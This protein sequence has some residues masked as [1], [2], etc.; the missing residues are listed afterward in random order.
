MPISADEQFVLLDERIDLAPGKPVGYSVTVPKSISKP[1]W[2]R[3]FS[4]DGKAR[5]IDPPIS[6]LKD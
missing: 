2:I 6:D 5:L 1:R 4:M 3:C